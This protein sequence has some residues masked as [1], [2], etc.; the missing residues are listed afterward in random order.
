MKNK[1]MQNKKFTKGFTLLEL[2]VVVLI[3]GILAAIALPQYK[4]AVEKARMAE[5]V[6]NVKAIAQAQQR[7]YM[8]YGEYAD[9]LDLNSLDIDLSGEDYNYHGCSAKKTTDFVYTSNGY[10][11]KQ[12]IAVASRIPPAK[13]YAILVSKDNPNRIICRVYSEV[14]NIQEEL[15]DALDANGTL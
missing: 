1:I 10:S 11:A 14:N 4:K 3:I 6:T 2:L 5:A 12:Y 13:R 7:Y 9:C 15:C 8:I